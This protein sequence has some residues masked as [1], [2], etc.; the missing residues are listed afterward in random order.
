[1]ANL[2]E[3]RGRIKSIKSIQ[4]VTSAMKMVAAAKLRTSQANMELCRPYSNRISMLLND[5]LL[6]CDNSNFDL[7]KQLINLAENSDILIHDAHFTDAD[8]INHKGWGHSSWETTIKLAEKVNV[9]KAVL[10]HYNPLYNDNQLLEIENK[11]K[12]AFP[13]TI[14]SK[15]GLK[16]NF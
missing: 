1:M 12:K 4:K 5:L 14:A 11:A 8:L 3:I 9:N 6:E 7:N 13:N 10:Y 16:I 15:Q 2:K